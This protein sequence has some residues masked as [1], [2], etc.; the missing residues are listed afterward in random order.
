[1]DEEYTRC[2]QEFASLEVSGQVSAGT[3]ITGYGSNTSASSGL[4]GSLLGGGG[5]Y[6]SSY[7]AAG[8]QEL[9]G[10]MYGGSAGGN[11]GSILDL[12]MGRSMT[13]DNAAEYILENHFDTSALT[14]NNG[15]ITLPEEQWSLV[16]AVVKNVFYDDG[17]GFI[18]L[19]CDSEFELSNNTLIDNF[20]GTWLSIDG[21]PFAYYYLNDVSEGD[22]YVIYGYSPAILNGERVNLIVNFD[23][24]RPYGYIAGAQKVYSDGES[25]TQ[26]KMMIA[27]GK[28]DRIQFVCDYYDYD[29]NYHDSYKLG[30]PITLGN[31]YEIANTPI[32]SD[33]N[34]CRVTYRFT[35]LYQ[36]DYWTPAVQ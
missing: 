15:K 23:S 13:A 28:G 20:D 7:S 5:G 31:T 22:E 19:G 36:Q 3:P 4:L 17:S 32:S 29:G 30:N 1:M 6:S 26:A 16:T 18:D 14:W 33:M 2:I 10:G 21:Q 24:E 27:I 9:L 8:L 25:D 34:R 35:D 12:F 11:T